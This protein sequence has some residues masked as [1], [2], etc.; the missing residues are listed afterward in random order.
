MCLS[1]YILSLSF[2]F[3]CST[4]MTEKWKIRYCRD[5]E[6]VK[7]SH[8]P[9]PNGSTN[10]RES[11]FVNVVGIHWHSL[12]ITRSRIDNAIICALPCHCEFRATA[13]RCEFVSLSPQN[14]GISCRIETQIRCDNYCKLTFVQES[15]NFVQNTLSIGKHNFVHNLHVSFLVEEILKYLLIAFINVF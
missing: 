10:E 8:C 13:K 3:K 7:F 4:L 15:V 11:N 2:T 5:V 9:D 6:G 12:R 14:I 1:I